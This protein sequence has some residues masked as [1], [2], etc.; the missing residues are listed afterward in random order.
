[1]FCNR[2]IGNWQEP[3]GCLII[4]YGL[5]A[6]DQRHIIA[7][8]YHYKLVIVV[9]VVATHGGGNHGGP[10]VMEITL[11]HWRWRSKAQER[12]YHVTL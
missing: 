12:L 3:Y 9:V 4:L 7:L 1:M 5:R 2:V 6:N 8:L 10:N 11:V